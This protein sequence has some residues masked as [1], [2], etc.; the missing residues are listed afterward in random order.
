MASASANVASLNFKTCVLINSLNL[1]NDP[2][3]PLKAQ[4]K[5][6]SSATGPLSPFL[7]IPVNQ[8][9]NGKF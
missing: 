5:D 6:V 3:Q 4:P 9:I 2:T 8:N 1:N 7:N